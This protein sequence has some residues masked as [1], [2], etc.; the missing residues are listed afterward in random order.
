MAANGHASLHLNNC[1]FN[2]SD[3]ISQRSKDKDFP[4]KLDY[5]DST[6]SGVRG[7]INQGGHDFYNSYMENAHIGNNVALKNTT[8]A[9]LN[10][11]EHPSEFE[12]VRANN[13][14]LSSTKPAVGFNKIIE[15]PKSLFKN[16]QNNGAHGDGAHSQATRGSYGEIDM[17]M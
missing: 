3:I 13:I 8:L 6:L 14:N 1:G 4:I 2:G 9:N 12:N 11:T 7:R 5:E 10:D 15:N 16:K 17:D